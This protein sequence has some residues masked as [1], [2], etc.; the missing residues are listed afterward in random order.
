MHPKFVKL[1]LR[2]A[3]ASAFLS[4]VA[5]R[6]GFWEKE[7]SVWGN[8]HSFVEYTGVITPWAPPSLTPSLG[9]I[10]TIAEVV[11]AVGLL[12]GFKTKIVAI[13]SGSLLCPACGRFEFFSIRRYEFVGDINFIIRQ[14]IIFANRRIFFVEEVF[15]IFETTVFITIQVFE[16]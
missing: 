5:D 10:A 4:A 12:L 13:G 15:G 16:V 9:V 2:L 11:L 14:L 7:V 6:F 8:W 1:F 3:I